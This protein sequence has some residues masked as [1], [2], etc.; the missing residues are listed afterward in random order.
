MVGQ[1]W[2]TILLFVHLQVKFQRNVTWRYIFKARF[3][4]DVT[5]H[6][7]LKVRKPSKCFWRTS[8][9]L[10]L[11]SKTFETLFCLSA[12]TLPAAQAA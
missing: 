7:I 1:F 5:W 8:A 10:V 2:P 4:R 11:I 3:Q 6:Y 9:N 12:A